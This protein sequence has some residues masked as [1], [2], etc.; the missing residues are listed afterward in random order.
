MLLGYYKHIRLYLGYKYNNLLILYYNLDEETNEDIN[1]LTK[2]KDIIQMLKRVENRAKKF[3]LL[4]GRG[5]SPFQM[6]WRRS[7]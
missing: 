2:D 1:E 4:V 5:S 6:E 3:H 7:I